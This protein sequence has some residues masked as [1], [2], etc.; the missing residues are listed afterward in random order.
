MH[1]GENYA[2]AETR[3]ITISN[4]ACRMLIRIAA[5][6]RRF[7]KPPSKSPVSLLKSPLSGLGSLYFRRARLS[8][9][10]SLVCVCAIT[11]HADD[12]FPSVPRTIVHTFFGSYYVGGVTVNPHPAQCF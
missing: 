9:G 7:R 4:I 2:I 6:R 8:R 5:T 11:A 3:A 1:I 10:E 12:V